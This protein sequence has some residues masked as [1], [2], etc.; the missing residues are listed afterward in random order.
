MTFFD[1]LAVIILVIS[2]L[3][4]FFRGGA[5]EIVSA[6]SVLV[7][8]LIA[9]LALPITGKIGR[10]ILD[11]DWAGTVAAVVVVFV[12]VGLMLRLVAAW[13]SQ[14][15]QEHD[16]LGG[17]DRMAGLGFGLLRGLVF[18]GIIH[19][20]LYAATPA[21]RIPHWYRGAMVYPAAKAS[22]KVLQLVLPTWA[23]FADKVAPAVED[24]VRRG[25]TDQPHSPAKRP[26][27]S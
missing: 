15:L 1:G 4:G 27:H 18:L 26:A 2:S 6:F 22:A 10:T 11:P 25:A 24:S 16:H 14:S 19:L 8:G 20:M 17:A 5:R 9:L 23:K 21:G 7:A 3:W 13:L 12:F